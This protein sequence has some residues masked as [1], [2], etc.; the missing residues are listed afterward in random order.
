MQSAGGE[1]RK[2]FPIIKQCLPL[3][4]GPELCTIKVEDQ[5]FFFIDETIDNRIIKER[6]SYAI[7]TVVQGSAGEKQTEQEFV[8][9]IGKNV[10]RWYA[11]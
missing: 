7:I 4:F 5:S 1:G 3:N 11:R 6:S 10:W 9:M 8:N 2:D